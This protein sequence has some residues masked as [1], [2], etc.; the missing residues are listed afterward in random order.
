MVKIILLI[1]FLIMFS[2][3]FLKFYKYKKL[4]KKNKEIKFN[5]SNLYQWMNLTKKERFDLSKKESNSYL[6]KRKSL[7]DE[8]RKEYKSISKNDQK[9]L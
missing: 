7:L 8:I 6:K 4:L 9:I 1:S 2:F 5:K 3:I